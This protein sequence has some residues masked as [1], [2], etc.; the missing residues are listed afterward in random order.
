[1]K[2]SQI[3]AA[4]ASSGHQDLRSAGKGDFE[5]AVSAGETDSKWEGRRFPASFP[6]PPV[7]F[8]SQL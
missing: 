6:L 4:E 3:G 5:G 2:L 1:M 7:L 8:I